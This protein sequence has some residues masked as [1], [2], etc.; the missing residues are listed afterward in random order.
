MIGVNLEGSVLQIMMPYFQ[1]IDGV[2][3]LEI[4]ISV[5]TLIWLQLP[6]SLSYD[7]VLLHKCTLYT[8]MG[9]DGLY[10]KVVDVV[11]RDQH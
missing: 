3:E 7:S 9:C 10:S 5:V 4:V 8:C 6:G 2:S 1:R 11:G